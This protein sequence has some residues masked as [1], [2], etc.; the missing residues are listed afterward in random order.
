MS[1]FFKFDGTLD[2]TYIDLGKE[3]LNMLK[4]VYL[5]NRQI[6]ILCIGTDRCTGDA[7]GPFIG[8]K[9]NS[10]Y[11][12]NFFIYGTLEYPVHAK[13][14]TSTI[15]KIYSIFK[16]PYIIAIDASLGKISDVGKISLKDSPLSPGL[17]LKKD[18][19]P[20]GNISITGVV[21]MSGNFEFLVLQNT[22]LYTVILLSNTISKALIY[23][24]RML[25]A[26][27]NSIIDATDI[28]QLMQEKNN[29]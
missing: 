9:L 6:I 27:T 13:N 4:P 21:N 26:D 28:F 16:N 22:R 29:T 7:L 8:D 12:N 1:N 20:I 10:M 11:L 24:D 14:L 2:E 19:P 5:K 25:S 15:D 18:L 23:A 17:A 3:L